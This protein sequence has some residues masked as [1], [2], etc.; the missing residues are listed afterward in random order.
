M[1]GLLFCL[2]LSGFG[3][4]SALPS[5][6]F[7]LPEVN[8]FSPLFPFADLVK[9]A[10]PLIPRTA[11]FSN[12][13]YSYTWAN[14]N[15]ADVS[16]YS[17][18]SSTGYPQA[19]PQNVV[20]AV[21][22]ATFDNR[23]P[24]IAPA[25]VPGRYVLS[26]KGK[27]SVRLH[28]DVAWDPQSSLSGSF[29]NA[30]NI[31]APAAN[32]ADASGAELPIVLSG[33]VTVASPGLTVVITATSRDD[34]LHG[35]ELVP[36]A[37]KRSGLRYDRGPLS[38]SP[39][40]LELT[41]RSLS[42]H[43]GILRFTAWQRELFSDSYASSG[44]R[45]YSWERRPLASSSYSQVNDPQGVSLDHAIDLVFITNASAVF[46]IPQRADDNYIRSFAAELASRLFLLPVIDGRHPWVDSA[47]VAPGEQVTGLY[48]GSLYFEYS[49]D[50]GLRANQAA[51][52]TAA[53]DQFEAG[54]LAAYQYHT[55][56][57]ADGS[58]AILGVFPTFASLR[59]RFLFTLALSRPVYLANCL[60][61]WD[62]FRSTAPP[63]SA[64]ANWTHPFERL[65]AIAVNWALQSVLDD[66]GWESPATNVSQW[67]AAAS[68][69]NGD[70][71]LFRHLQSTMLSAEVDANAIANRVASFSFAAGSYGDSPA[72]AGK[73]AV[74]FVGGKKTPTRLLAFDVG[75]NFRAP[76]FGARFSLANTAFASMPDEQKV[77]Y[78]AE[79]AWNDRLRELHRHPSVGRLLA[80]FYRRLSASG[81]EGII[82]S[83]LMRPSSRDFAWDLKL[84]KSGNAATSEAWQPTWPKENTATV[85]TAGELLSCSTPVPSD[86]SI[87]AISAHVDA[88]VA[89]SPKLAALLNFSRSPSSPPATA[90]SLT[91]SLSPL[92]NCSSGCKWGSCFDGTCFC[93]VGVTGA[94]CDTF[95]PAAAMQ[96][97]RSMVSGPSSSCGS[98]LL[99]MNVAGL[100]DYS[101]Q[102]FYVDAHKQ[103]RAWISQ[104]GWKYHRSWEWGF[105]Q[106]VAEQQLDASDYPSSRGL[107]KGIAIGTLHL[108]DLQGHYAAGWYSVSW[109]GEGVV[110]VSMTDVESV[111]RDG[112]GRTRVK[113]KPGTTLNNGLFL[114]IERSSPVDPVRNI[115]VI[116]PFPG[117]P[118]TAHND[119]DEKLLNTAFSASQPASLVASYSNWSIHSPLEA[120]ERLIRHAD[121]FPFHPML[122]SFLR[123]YSTL[124][125]MD[126]QAT[127]SADAPR[128]WAE[129][130]V[131]QDRT[132]TLGKGLPLE[133]LVL[134][135]NTLGANPWINVPAAANDDYVTRFAAML[136]KDLR[137]DLKVT[138]ELSNELW[139]PQFPG[140]SYAQ[141][142]GVLLGLDSYSSL[143]SGADEARFCW[144]AM[145]SR[146]VFEIFEG[147]WGPALRHRLSFVVSTQAVNADVGK[148][149][150]SCNASF[151]AHKADFLAIAPYLDGFA[152]GFSN[153]VK[154]SWTVDQLFSIGFA[155]E[156]ERVKRYLSD[157]HKLAA[158]F[159]L[160]LAAYEAGQGIIGATTAQQAL[161]VAAN[162]SPLMAGLYRQYLSLLQQA[163]VSPI[164]L[165][166]SVGLA[167]G[168]YGS[169]GLVEGLD[170]D[171]KDNATSSKFLGVASFLD[172][173]VTVSL[174]AI[175]NTTG[176]PLSRIRYTSRSAG[177][178]CR[179]TSY[180]DDLLAF[181][182]AEALLPSTVGVGVDLES[183][184]C[185]LGIGDSGLALPCSGR[186]TCVDSPLPGSTAKKACGC[187]AGWSGLRCD[188]GSFL[189]FST[190]SYQCSGHG[191]CE[192]TRTEGHRRYFACRCQA[193]YS[194]DRCT[195]FSCPNHC[196][197]NG[198]CID[199]NTCACYRGMA[200][201]D[202]SIDCA[203]PGSNGVCAWQAGAGNGSSTATAAMTPV[204][205]CDS[206]FEFQRATAAPFTV[207]TSRGH[208]IAG[209]CVPSCRCPLE[210]QTCLR[211]GV[212][213]LPYPCVNGDVIRGA[214]VCWQGFAGKSCTRKLRPREAVAA[215]A[216]ASLFSPMGINLAGLSY[217]SSETPLCNLM[218]TAAQWL[219]QWKEAARPSGVYQWNRGVTSPQNLSATT[220]YPL[221]LLADQALG[222]LMARDV[223]R[224]LPNGRYVVTYE[225]NGD[226]VFGFDAKVVEEK[227]GRIALDV[228][229]S[230]VRDNGIFM[231]V[232]DT[233]PNNPVRDIKI[234]M[235]S[236]PATAS[237]A[238]ALTNGVQ[239]EE[240]LRD[241]FIWHPLFLSRMRELQ[242]GAIRFMPAMET[243]DAGSEGG[244]SGRWQDRVTPQRAIW[245]G[246]G[247]LPLE[248][249]I[250]LCN[251]LGVDAWFTL[252][253]NADGDYLTRFATMVRDRLRPDLQ[254][255]VERSNEAWNSLFPAGKALYEESRQTGVAAPVLHARKSFEMFSVFER[256]FGPD[257]RQSRLIHVLST[258]TAN[259]WWTET[260]LLKVNTTVLA[261]VDALG[262]TAYMDCGNL[263]SSKNAQLTAL[264]DEDFVFRRCRE[265]LPFISSE[266]AGHQRVLDRAA[267]RLMNAS[268]AEPS[269]LPLPSPSPSTTP[270]PANASDPV[271]DL[272]FPIAADDD[273]PL[274]SRR[275]GGGGKRIRLAVYEGGPS[276]AEQAVIENAYAMPT[277]G[278]EQLFTQVSRS[279]KMERLYRDYLDSFSALGLAG[280]RQGA[281]PFMAF[282][283]TGLPSKY[284]AWGHLES[285]MQPWQESPKARAVLAFT[286]EV[287]KNLTRVGCTSPG[288]LNYDPLAVFPDDNCTYAPVAVSSSGA[289]VKPAGLAVALDF[290]SGAI[291]SGAAVAITVA[292][293]PL[294]SNNATTGGDS[295]AGV[296]EVA[297]NVYRF[298]PA[299][300]QFDAPVTVCVDLTAAELAELGYEALTDVSTGKMIVRQLGTSSATGT[301]S[302]I[303]MYWRS[304][305]EGSE[306]TLAENSTFV[307][308]GSPIGGGNNNATTAQ[309]CGLLRHFTLV[310]GMVVHPQ[311]LAS[312]AAAIIAVSP[313]GGGGGGGGAG[314]GAASPSPA[315]APPAADSPGSNTGLS[316][317]GIAGI[318]VA[319]LCVVVIGGLFVVRWT[320]AAKKKARV[321]AAPV[322]RLGAAAVR[323]LGAGN[324]TVTFVRQVSDASTGTAVSE[325]ASRNVSASGV[326]FAD[327]GE[328][329]EETFRL[330]NPVVTAAASSAT[331]PVALLPP[332]RSR[333]QRV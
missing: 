123:N 327:N 145:R 312:D 209:R 105:P 317:G 90:G 307:A 118:V 88:L 147:V 135:S 197:W 213:S 49:N 81:Y 266:W 48:Q 173:N 3:L 325:T 99:G 127:N 8:E 126:L 94:S 318:A 132:F 143:A 233:D 319:A 69:P 50:L 56:A 121:A 302:T 178:Q 291:G 216:Y 140:G 65:D 131:P 125:M 276:L 58:S 119:N 293:V 47:P 67:L 329:A 30:S 138:V 107:T 154:D 221:S 44:V 7:Q 194:G 46:S 306:W 256:V 168:V 230:T 185:P 242:F 269:Q 259:P 112:P 217:Y 310:A 212:C 220:G 245:A 204:A 235:P 211:P 25:W 142:Q 328:G 199:A 264:K 78:S 16:T 87:A 300:T 139:G 303:A 24:A 114:R 128:T 239:C 250:H 253:H 187:I 271:L 79:T 75:F 292:Q 52:A 179:A 1:A 279:P 159:N 53:F 110:D 171:P 66:S 23:F 219:S 101:T 124:R 225:G 270:L 2:L 208:Y 262:V 71:V 205:V 11:S 227:K 144:Y 59:S 70:T 45:D 254:V 309:L 284:G 210:S 36:V 98:P 198:R 277:A 311:Q 61:I 283:S 267:E 263:G 287:V 27:G 295:G 290:P 316:A 136:L 40:F 286:A 28:G 175:A 15:P 288:A 93:F 333:G 255:F 308:S 108:R 289:S 249:T 234:A 134:L 186:G 115:R 229:L 141:A 248:A 148:R 54:L 156:I 14:P 63:R 32:N 158:S 12:G 109:D 26:W 322:S 39:R 207:S 247:G 120:H 195:V 104:A 331:V 332:H 17:F 196:S 215:G 240:L 83:D 160:S 95:L 22:I 223:N 162:R 257:Q 285:T 297:T 103:S 35:L 31:V 192:L 206:G 73:A 320:A 222:T 130:P 37:L 214:C 77:V 4:S 236:T 111:I 5:S 323:P 226:L 261:S 183:D 184:S 313:T 161:V 62:N 137:P 51:L 164:M 167:H 170:F 237:A 296:R 265:V 129:R 193:G 102:L 10:A 174:A 191:T 304:Q 182:S 202:C 246:F 6:G 241:G 228:Q 18:N 100:A 116:M 113:L 152:G 76:D 33:N 9:H 163:G 298:G 201:S 57:S 180:F 68:T 190:C 122:L 315:A 60:S 321:K 149:I 218:P 117:S 280:G 282:S 43:G 324:A 224:T 243:N 232:E 326:Q 273:A 74:D 97:T 251:V 165:Y 146:Q 91:A 172:A 258:F 272:G 38:F 200:G 169:W 305:D 29:V 41:K 13:A 238:D 21:R 155:Q 150:L 55:A 252:P 72:L 42:S 80:E 92:K 294:V 64:V 85:I 299:G 274:L 151:V 231:Q 89:V 203:G 281:F 189:D 34:H 157:H 166:S 133:H 181:S 268:F 96:S 176:A 244:Q 106:A 86:A 188:L 330:T 84:R 153:A 301:N 20:F 314:G 82:A 19:L 278:L 177:L 275:N 260:M